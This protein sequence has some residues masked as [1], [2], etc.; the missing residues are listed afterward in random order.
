[1]TVL[2]DVCARVLAFDGEDLTELPA[3]ALSGL[4]ERSSSAARRPP[5]S[6]ARNIGNA[7][8]GVAT[9]RVPGL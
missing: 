4:V 6:G 3:A 5:R 1:M 2:A 9:G 8:K 7:V